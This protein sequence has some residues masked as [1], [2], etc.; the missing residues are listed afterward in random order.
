MELAG[1]GLS[2][3]FLPAYVTLPIIVGALPSLHASQYMKTLCGRHVLVV[4]TEALGV[5][6]DTEEECLPFGSHWLG[7]TTS[8][9]EANI[10]VRL[11][12]GSGYHIVRIE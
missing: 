6:L 2:Y 4:E 12:H 7:F 10:K 9:S 3:H 5:W 8:I 11:G 1:N